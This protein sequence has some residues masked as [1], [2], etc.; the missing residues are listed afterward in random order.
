MI[1]ESNQKVTAS[2]LK[3]TAYLYVRQSTIQQVYEHRESTK[4]QYEL[5]RRA[6]A[7]GWHTQQIQV[8]DCDLGQSGASSAD[9][10][11]FKQLVSEV[12]LGH[13]GIV[14]G[15]EVSRLARNSADWHRLLEIC[16]LSD[17]L[18]LDED[19][20]Y[21]PNCFND[22]LLLGLKGTMSEA[23]LHLLYSR[24]Q[25]GKLSKA[26]RG[27]LT[28]RLP[29]GYV[30]DEEKRVRLDPD[31]QVRE[32][33]SLFFKTF[34]RTG[35][36]MATLKYFR[37]EKILFPR[38]LC[39]G[40]NRGEL[41]WGELSYSRTLQILH[42]PRYA[43]VFVYGRSRHRKRADGS[44]SCTKLPQDEWYAMIP[45]AHPAYISWKEYE[46]NQKRLKEN[47]QANGADRRQSPPRE[48]P[49]LLQGLIVCG[50][51]GRRMTLRYYTRN[52]QLHPTY[53]CQVEGI[54]NGN[55]ICQSIPGDEIDEAVGKL[56]LN[57][58]TPLSLEVALAV[59]Q[60]LSARVE[61][62]ERLRLK[63]VERARYEAKLAQH[64]YMQVDPD[65]R[66]VADALEADW[67]EKLRALAQAQEEYKRQCQAD[68]MFIGEQERAQIISLAAD[69]P[70]LWNNPKTSNRERKRML[71]LLVEDVT[72]IKKNGI[73]VHV[74]FKGGAANTL[75]LP[76]PQ[77]AWQIRQTPPEVIAEIERLLEHHTDIQIAAQLNERGFRPGKG[78]LFNS[79]IVARIR[80]DNALKDRYFHLRQAGKLT[81]EEM[82]GKLKVNVQTVKKWWRNGLLLG[83]PYN[84][85][86]ECLYEP[87]GPDAPVKGKGSNLSKRRVFPMPTLK[88]RSN[89]TKEVQYEA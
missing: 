83:Y 25:G 60:E 74:R 13:A 79:R 28:M 59:Q 18:I 10:E 6:V 2:H 19:G 8:I 46:D 71:R 72:L 24:M 30:Y 85:K 16:A 5:R 69:F 84:D 48:G 33:I 35:A 53:L 12:G 27:E 52:N 17:T 58:L 68:R 9:R 62:A 26:R 76:A 36:A 54:R 31:K 39:T 51:C 82:A 55:P 61:E 80:K 20:L 65:N 40:L 78:G 21:N 73:T 49:A 67:N 29:V 64:R 34:I 3:R 81:A 23:E 15:L 86:N 63:Q 22:R 56:V 4:R 37:Q 42:N 89:R 50:V 45:E 70:K 75:S 7:L 57:T 41:L 14:L 66:L 11:G 88:V 77:P 87:P 47:A 38:R 44:R 1:Q 32:T 43:G